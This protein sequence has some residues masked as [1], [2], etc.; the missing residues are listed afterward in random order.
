MGAAIQTTGNGQVV[1]GEKKPADVMAGLLTKMGPEMAKA[2]P[3]HVSPD[4]MVRITTTAL[5]ANPDLALCTQV[6]FLG[7]VLSAAQLGLEVNTPLGQAYL[8]PRKNKGVQECTLQIGYQ[9]MLDLAR[10]SGEVSSIYAEAV[11]P[12]DTFEYELGLDRTLKHKPS[13][14]ANREDVQANLT[15]VYAVAKLK[16]GDAL[17]VVLTKAQVE[18]YKKR[19][20]G[21]PAWSSDYEAMAK[22]TAIRRLFTWIPKSAEVA[23]AIALDEAPEIGRPQVVAFDPNVTAALE[24]HGIEVIQAP[25]EHVDEETGEVTTEPVKPLREPGDDDE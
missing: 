8:I 1:R 3:K 4:R 9:G 7:C 14:E 21:G 23:G 22:K 6:S 5:R 12:G 24:A 25:G 18:R 13:G 10:R 15:H 20:A 16:S 19:G 2:L 11:Y 17:F